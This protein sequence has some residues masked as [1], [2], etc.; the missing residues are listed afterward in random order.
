MPVL[1]AGKAVE[2]VDAM[3][4]EDAADRH[5]RDALCDFVLESRHAPVH[6]PLL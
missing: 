4:F 3:T 1:G 6:A 5:F 2:G